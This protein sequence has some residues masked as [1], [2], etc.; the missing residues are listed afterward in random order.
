M[1]KKVAAT[2]AE[3]THVKSNFLCSLGYGDHSK[4]FARLARL[5]FAS[6]CTLL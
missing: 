6:A 2:S 5:D 3:N 1:R 4:V